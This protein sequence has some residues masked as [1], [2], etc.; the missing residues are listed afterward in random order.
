MVA[1]YG[2]AQL[3]KYAN[4]AITDKTASE[5]Y[6]KDGPQAG[7]SALTHAPVGNDC[8]AWMKLRWP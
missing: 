8:K 7:G 4:L 6:G 1:V 5:E 3:H 2:V